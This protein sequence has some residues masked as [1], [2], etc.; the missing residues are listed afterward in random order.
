MRV[1]AVLRGRAYF[2]RKGKRKS[3]EHMCETKPQR[4]AHIRTCET[5]PQ[6][7]AILLELP[8]KPHI[9]LEQ[10]SQVGNVVFEACHALDTYTKGEA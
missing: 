10:H 1:I 6:R 2:V 3:G 4:R 9:A 7:R 8:Q 5:K